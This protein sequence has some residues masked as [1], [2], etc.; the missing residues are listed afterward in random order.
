MKRS[1]F[2][3]LLASFAIAPA[4]HAGTVYVPVTKD[5]LQGKV[6][7][8]KVW[9]T[10]TSS[11]ARRFSYF[12]ILA[13]SNG[14]QRAGAPE[15]LTVPAGGTLL[16]SSLA[17]A[18][19]VGVLEITGA[20]QLVVTA[21]LDASGLASAPVASAHLPVVSSENQIGGGKV[22]FLQGLA[23]GQAGLLSNLGILNLAHEG[24]Q[25]TVG[26]FRSNGT[27]I[28]TN[29]VL[30]LQALS[31]REFSDAYGLLQEAAIADSYFAVTCARDFYAYATLLDP[32]NTQTVYVTPSYTLASSLRVPGQPGGPPGTVQF[33]LPGV[34]LDAKP[35]DSFKVFD[36]PA[37]PGTRYKKAVVEFDLRV[38][39]MTLGP[40]NFYGVTSLRRNDKTLFFGLIVRDDRDKT[41]LDLGEEVEG[42]LILGDNGGPWK[43]NANY[44]VIFEY[45]TDLREVV[46][47]LF[48][49]GVLVEQLSGRTL[50]ND[51]I[52]GGNLLRVDFGMK[53][54]ADGAYF[55]P[56]TWRYSNLSVRL[57]PF[58]E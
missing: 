56:H 18:G 38:G 58:E 32:V 13:D 36:L 21:R 46:F 53:G 20:P 25:C 6:Y 47:K 15:S 51:L 2:L 11:V 16:L 48:R 33:S 45:D 35:G 4:L 3:A 37:D 10:N 9:V 52:A 41:I 12:F 50:H 28:G 22:A 34:F 5:E 43:A 40:R 19:K 31:N 7:R 42:G 30:T 55:P 1:L 54:I 8:T 17:P 49:A 14:T 26:A 39:Q 29:A 24:N 44:Y 23:R 27:Q 57:E